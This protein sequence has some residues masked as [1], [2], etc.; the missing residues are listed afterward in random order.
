[1]TLRTAAAVTPL[2]WH[3]EITAANAGHVWESTREY[4]ESPKAERDLALDLSGVRFI[5]SS[6]LSLLIRAKK[7]ARQ[8]GGKLV[9]RG[10]QPAVKN[11]IQISHLN[12]FLQDDEADPNSLPKHPPTWRDVFTLPDAGATPAG[13]FGAAQNTIEPVTNPVFATSHE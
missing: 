11:V 4:L 8:Q 2:V 1:M 10:V 13:I 9:F 7:L 6:G 3:G 5:D 12:E